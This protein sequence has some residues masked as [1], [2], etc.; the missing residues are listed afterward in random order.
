MKLQVDETSLKGVVILTP[1]IFIDSRGQFIEMYK[2]D[3]FRNLG[4]PSPF[5]QDNLSYSRKNVI[6]GLHFQWFPAMGKL[7]RV[8]H[9]KAFIVAVDIRKK[10]PSL[11]KWFGVEMSSHSRQQI[12]APPG[13]AMGFCALSE[14]TEIYYKCTGLYN[15]NF[16][17]NILWNDTEI[18]IKWPIKNPII[19]S[20]DKKA[21]TLKQ[22]LNRKESNSFTY[23]RKK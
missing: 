10:S 9:G 18:G 19:S 8:N 7:M 16:E 6:R 15:S 1:D 17:S 12:Y 14:P 21:Q 20:R 13:F 5:V 3:V 11:G 2:R 22:W 4:I 23:R